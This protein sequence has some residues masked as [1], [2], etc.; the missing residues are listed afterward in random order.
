MIIYNE[1]GE[2]GYSISGPKG[3][4]NDWRKYKQLEVEQKQ[5]QK[6]EMERLIKKLAMTCRS[7]LDLKKDQ[8]KQNEMKDKIKSK[9][10]RMGTK[11]LHGK[12]MLVKTFCSLNFLVAQG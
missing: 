1:D 3:V 11:Y 5:E 2:T 7:D 10:S 8:E 12:E 6:K 9:V 4:I